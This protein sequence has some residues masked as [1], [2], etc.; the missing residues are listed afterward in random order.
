MNPV[1]LP[2]D[3]DVGLVQP[4][5]ERALRRRVGRGLMDR[6]ALADTVGVDIRTVEG[7]FN[8]GR[9]PPLPIWFRL[10]MVLGPDFENEIRG[11]Q[12][13]MASRAI[14]ALDLDTAIKALRDTASQLETI[15][16]P[17]NV[18]PIRKHAGG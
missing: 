4:R 13:A 18:V 11:G 6:V 2:K 9:L 17:S 14:S 15:A 7:W 1:L 8:D 10:C 3:V 16:G 12:P 5:F